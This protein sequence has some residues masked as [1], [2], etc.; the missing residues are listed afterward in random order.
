MCQKFLI[1]WLNLYLRLL[2]FIN[3][4]LMLQR[5]LILRLTGA[6]YCM[7]TAFH[8]LPRFLGILFSLFTNI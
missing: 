5:W 4:Y 1:L 2:H 7:V 3:A 8:D 6:F